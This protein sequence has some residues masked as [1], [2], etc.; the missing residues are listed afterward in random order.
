MADF[1]AQYLDYNSF[2]A[3]GGLLGQDFNGE[4]DYEVE[5][6]DP[7]ST[8]VPEEV[9]TSE[10]NAV[11]AYTAGTTLA[12]AAAFFLIR[13]TCSK[14][15]Q[16]TNV[17]KEIK[18]RFHDVL[19]NDNNQSHSGHN[20]RD[21]QARF[22]DEEAKGHISKRDDENG[23]VVKKD[24][25]VVNRLASKFGF[26]HKNKVQEDYTSLPDGQIPSGGPQEEQK[27]IWTPDGPVLIEG[28]GKSSLKQNPVKAQVVDESSSS[29]SNRLPVDLNT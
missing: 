19:G 27:R 23:N 13:R 14:V 10:W 11:A 20:R 9:D 28:A 12:L 7:V 6:P 29:Q 3:S 4:L 18:K 21:Q 5:L 24:T 22:I 16:K 25:G 8:E 1:E 2:I 17:K 15:N 26:T